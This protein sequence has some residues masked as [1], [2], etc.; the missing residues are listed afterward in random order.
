MPP[1]SVSMITNRHDSQIDGVS[2]ATLTGMHGPGIGRHRRRGTSAGVAERDQR[3][4]S[5]EQARRGDC[6]G[7]TQPTVARWHVGPL[8]A[9]R[10]N[11][12]V[13]LRGGI[14]AKRRM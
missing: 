12:G 5:H 11:A 4:A 8:A 14:V 7:T 1:I 3:G 10:R 9:N 2:R 13:G 6:P